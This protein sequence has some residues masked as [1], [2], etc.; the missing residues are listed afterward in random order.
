[1]QCLGCQHI[2][3]KLRLEQSLLELEAIREENT[4]A[5]ELLCLV[6]FFQHQGVPAILL[7]SEGEDV[8]DFQEAASLLETFSFVDI[9]NTNSR[10]AT[11]KLVQLTTKWWL[12]REDPS[13]TEIW[14][15]KTLG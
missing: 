1:M 5:A 9:D 11:R 15:A 13:K 8:F 4:R 7:R 6:S 14:A 12:G 10:F 2:S 3:L